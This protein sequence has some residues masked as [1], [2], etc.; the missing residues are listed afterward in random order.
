MPSHWSDDGDLIIED[1]TLFRPVGFQGHKSGVFYSDAPTNEQE[2]G[3]YSPIY[4]QIA[5]WVTDEGWKD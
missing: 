3:G 2:P 5:T 4:I 1:K